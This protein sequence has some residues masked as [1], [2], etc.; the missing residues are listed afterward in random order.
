[1]DPDRFNG[2]DSEEKEDRGF[3]DSCLFGAINRLVPS[4]EEINLQQ[5]DNPY[6]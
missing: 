1:M 5:I 4:K 3:I 6:I 2:M